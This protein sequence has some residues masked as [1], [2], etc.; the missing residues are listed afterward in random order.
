VCRHEKVFDELLRERRAPAPRRA[1][2][3]VV[4]YGIPDGR[5]VDAVVAE[6]ARVL[7]GHDGVLQVIRDGAARDGYY[8]RR[9]RRSRHV[10][11]QVPLRLDA[12]HRR[13][14]L[15]VGYKSR[16]AEA[17]VGTH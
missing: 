3:Q 12:C 11:L 17:Q 13:G 9:V 14:I 4:L 10:R 6:K 1:A 8:V 7:G 2:L 16:R 15:R 5:P